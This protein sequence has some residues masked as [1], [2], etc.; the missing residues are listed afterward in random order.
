MPS[1]GV[2][3]I[4]RGRSHHRTAASRSGNAEGRGLQL[5]ASEGLGVE[6]AEEHARQ[7]HVAAPSGGLQGPDLVEDEH[8]PI[9]TRSLRA[10]T[11]LAGELQP[12]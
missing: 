9:V 3:N 11:R 12:R 7:C 10:G 6:L 8:V 2:N 4:S 1:V 5:A